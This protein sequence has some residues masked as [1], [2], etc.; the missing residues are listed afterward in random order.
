MFGGV[1]NSIKAKTIMAAI[2]IGIVPIKT[3]VIAKRDKT[4][5]QIIFTEISFIVVLV[6]IR[7]LIGRSNSSCFDS[8]SKLL[9]FDPYKIA[10][11]GNGSSN[12][13]MAAV[14]KLEPVGVKLAPAV[15]AKENKFIPA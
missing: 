1:T 9:I 15:Q 13:I 6:P 7:E 2:Y 10:D 4:A 12:I 14:E 3:R 8:V 11:S 5:D